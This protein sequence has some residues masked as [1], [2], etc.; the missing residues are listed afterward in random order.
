MP[1]D[2]TTA[3][4]LQHAWPRLRE[5]VLE[6]VDRDFGFLEC[7]RLR[8]DRFES[9]LAHRGIAWPRSSAGGLCWDDETF[10]DM[11]RAYPEIRPLRELR[12]LQ[13]DFDPRALALGRD[14]RNRVQLRPFATRTGRNAPSAKTSVMAQAAWVR[15]LV[16]PAPG[17]GLALIDWC[18]Q[19]FGIAAAL[20]GDTAMQKAYTSG[21][22]YLAL[23]IIA[24][25]A[26]ADATAAT[27]GDIR[28][29]TKPARSAFSTAWVGNDYPASLASLSG[30]LVT[31]S[32]TIDRRSRSSGVGRTPWNLRHCW[33]ES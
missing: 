30:K 21:D 23:A 31:C 22:P 20:S 11:A 5:R 16:C 27:H 9:W 25:A 8:L 3:E 28:P 32:A 4:R 19:E 24:G 10:R 14:G 26:P 7:G 29:G 17:T 12:A 6:I 33:K 1:A 15:H 2:L 18:Q 13:C